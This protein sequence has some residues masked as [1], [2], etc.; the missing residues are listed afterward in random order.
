MGANDAANIFG[1][2][3]GTKMIKFRTA[4]IICSIFIILGAVISGAGASNTLGRLG[5]VSTLPG[6]FTV[7]LAAALAVFGMSRFKFP[8]STSQAI[9]GSIVGWNIYSGIQTDYSTL[10]KIVSTWIICPAMAALF[11]AMFYMLA[12][13]IINKL[14]IHLI[15]LDS[16]TRWGLVIVG[17]F[18][19]Y[20]LGAN[21]IANVMGVFV[22]SSP[23]RDIRIGNL[24]SF[25]S[26]Q[27]LFLLGGVAISIGIFTYSYRIMD[28]VGADIFKLSPIAALIAV[29]ASSLVLFIFAS[30]GLQMWLQSH[31]LPTLPLVPV[32]SSQA[33]VGAIMGIGITKSIRNLHF[34]ILGKISMGWVTTPVIAGTLSYFL[35]FFVQNVF[36]LEVYTVVK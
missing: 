5:A 13:M 11:A 20:S 31:G 34:K 3:V 33:I 17:A 8:V 26:T 15:K 27:Q 14:K 9:V 23:F 18:G 21:N 30:E 32:S 24:F 22:K 6:A 29:L 28:T 1:T 10:T 35:L 36:M 25:T 19:S 2:A 7:A 4:A 12:K 16:Y